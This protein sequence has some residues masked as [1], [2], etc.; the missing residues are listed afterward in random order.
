M[1]TKTKRAQSTAE[2]AILLALVVA[3]AMGIQN[4]VR[5]AIQARVHDASVALVTDTGGTTMQYEPTE[6]TKTTTDQKS[7]RDVTENYEAEG[8]NEPW[9]TTQ[10]DSSASYSST[11]KQ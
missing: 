1:L 6:T 5:R 11:T 9:I 8:N 2:Y 7:S 10:E 3:A 4:E